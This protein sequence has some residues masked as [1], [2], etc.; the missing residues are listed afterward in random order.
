M[1]CAILIF[2]GLLLR[3]FLEGMNRRNFDL[4]GGEMGEG[5]LECT[6]ETADQCEG[7]FSEYMTDWLGY[8]MVGVA[9]VVVAVPEG[10]PLAVMIS[11]AYSVQK[12]LKD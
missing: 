3:T 1:Y 10:L 4:F 9:I 8:A 11:L 2:H 7:L 5:G 6:F 12:M